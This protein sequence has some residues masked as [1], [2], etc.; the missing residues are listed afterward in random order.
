[1]RWLG[2]VALLALLA[3]TTSFASV[4]RG[5]HED[6]ETNALF[7]NATKALVEG[8]PGDA[9]AGF[10]ALA[11]RGVIDP[12]VSLDRGLA[13][14]ARVRI[15]AEVPGDLGRAAHGFEEARELTASPK[16]AEDASRALAIVRAE[17]ARR[18]AQA[19][20]PAEVDPGISLGRSI[21]GLVPENVWG[22][23]A[24]L[25]SLAL[26]VALFV[27]ARTAR[28]T[29]MRRRRVG[30]ETATAISLPVL[31]AC[32]VLM[33]AARADR[34]HRR[35]GV[36]VSANAR[37]AGEDH[38]TLSSAAAL[39]EAARVEIVP[40]AE[41]KPG[42]TRVRWASVEGWLPSTSVRVISRPE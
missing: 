31:V 2:R 37:P 41:E 30:A 19:G 16:V 17:V 28:T 18:R 29:E 23:I 33:L 39:P 24:L 11:D 6:D 15:S 42:W 34:L 3:L 40:S 4:A 27:R 14:A 9:I 12:Q 25:G 8:R 36:I 21:V 5:D 22:S 26:G 38:L 13:Y 7:A 35:E 10:E 32:T 20:Q 1:M